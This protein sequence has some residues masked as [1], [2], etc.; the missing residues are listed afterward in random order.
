MPGRHLLTIA[1]GSLALMMS[2]QP[3]ESGPS[4]FFEI[5][6]DQASD[7][8]S[9]KE[10]LANSD[11]E[12]QA[13]AKVAKPINPPLSN[14]VYETDQLLTRKKTGEVKI[15]PFRAVCRLSLG[16]ITAKIEPSRIVTGTGP[17]GGIPVSIAATLRLGPQVIADSL[18]FNELCHAG[19]DV[20]ESI[21]VSGRQK[22]VTVLA[23][24]ETE[25]Y[26]EIPFTTVFPLDKRTNVS[27]DILTADNHSLQ[28]LAAVLEG[29][30]EAVLLHLENGANLNVADGLGRTPLMFASQS[31]DSDL[32]EIFL[33]KGANPNTKDK[34][35]K[36]ALAWGLYV[37][38]E[39]SGT[40]RYEQEKTLKL[41]VSRGADLS[42]KDEDGKS[43]L[44]RASDS[45]NHELVSLL[46]ELG[47]KD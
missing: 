22:A 38:H 41:L 5:N 21:S 3:A 16:T 30:S 17:C 37:P 42:V 31:W 13:L 2:A 1:I 43:V 44:I 25:N 15:K 11:R 23:H 19:G 47:A 29:N 27:H 39:F 10:I 20:I 14:G 26:Q 24:Y 12:S 46:R 18:V 40:V 4:Y 7:T 6:C 35:G 33:A 45:G 9:I 32:V 28:L 34:D 8:F 36:T